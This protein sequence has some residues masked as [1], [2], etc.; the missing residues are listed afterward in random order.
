MTGDFRPE[1]ELLVPSPAGTEVATSNPMRREDGCHAAR[2]LECPV[3]AGGSRGNNTVTDLEKAVKSARN[4]RDN[5]MKDFPD[6][7]SHEPLVET[8]RIPS[9]ARRSARSSS[10]I[11]ARADEYTAIDSGELGLRT[12]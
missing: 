11:Q 9:A 12:R 3:G 7:T 10:G 2:R 5:R 6:P 1:S 8:S 4:A